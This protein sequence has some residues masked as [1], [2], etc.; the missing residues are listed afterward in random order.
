MLA[1]DHALVLGGIKGMLESSYDVVG[2]AEDGRQLVRAAEELKPDIILLDI[3]MPQ[4]NGIEVA[5]RLAKS[6]PDTKLI[7]VTMHADATFVTAALK[8]GASG[9]VIKKSAPREL[10]KAIEEV[11][12]GRTYVTPLVT[13]GFVDSVLAPYESSETF[14]RLTP[15]QREVLQLVA[16]GHSI[17]E[18]AARL[19]ISPKTVEFHKSRIMKALGLRNTA[20]LVKYALKH[21]IVSIEES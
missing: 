15:R 21:G 3:S 17:K 11:R 18:I 7:F 2:V 19:F 9:Y 20:E 5:R 10:V 4:L 13:R 8:A 16:E 14:G 6:L 1:D 12:R